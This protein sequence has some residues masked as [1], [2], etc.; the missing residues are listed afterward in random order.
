MSFHPN[1][2][3]IPGVLAKIN[4][5]P[6]LPDNV[7]AEELNQPNITVVSDPTAVPV[8]RDA[9]GQLL[10]VPFFVNNKFQTFLSNIDIARTDTS[11][12]EETRSVASA[13]Y[14]ILA[15]GTEPIDFLDNGNPALIAILFDK[16]IEKSTWS[17]P[18]LDT[19]TKNA[20]LALGIESITTFISW[21]KKWNLDNPT[22][23]IINPLNGNVEDYISASTIGAYRL[24]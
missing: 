10:I 6:T 17:R 2:S 8:T 1:F 12:D 15:V 22:T 20:I 4:E 14:N 13:A 11:A 3:I 24:G 23:K 5:Y 19:T 7:L 21:V 16:L 9:I 18:L